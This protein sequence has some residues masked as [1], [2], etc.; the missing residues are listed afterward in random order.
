MIPHRQKRGFVKVHFLVWE[1]AMVRVNKFVEIYKTCNNGTNEGKYAL[2]KNGELTVPRYVDVELT[3]M[4]NFKCCFCPTGTRSMQRVKG[5]MS[6]EVINALVTN[7]QKYQIPGVR[8]IRWGEPT[9]HPRYIEIMQR[10]KA[11]GAAIHI[12]TNGSLLDEEQIARLIDMQ[13]DSIKFSFQGA[14]EGTYNEM[15]EGGDYHH[16]LDVIKK[17]A[18][19]RGDNPLPYIQISTTLTGETVTQ[20]DSFKHDIENYCDYYNIGYTQL[21]H[22]NVDNMNIDDEEKK[23][24]KYLQEHEKIN[25]VYNP[26]CVEAFDKLSINWNGDVTLCCGDYDNF[27]I[28]GNI[29]D[30]D[31]KQIFTGRA[32]NQYREII[33]KGQ[34]GKI[35]CCSTCYETVPLTK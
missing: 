12:N 27:L 3:N 30:A 29:L 26:V 35:K 13:L 7:I 8:F 15:R 6:E 11:V 34:Y 23:K 33:A 28:V 4:C 17:M 19:M 20:I 9:L 2:I 21:N 31:L 18:E 16:L 14:D 5:Y 24:I 32:A 25:H 1:D 10:I 22:L